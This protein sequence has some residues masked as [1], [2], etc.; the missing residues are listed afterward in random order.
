MKRFIILLV[1]S[2]IVLSSKAQ[3]SVSQKEIGLTT[4]D[5]E[6]FGL[7]YMSGTSTSLWR[8]S[9]F[10]SSGNIQEYIQDTASNTLNKNLSVAFKIGKEFRKMVAKN[11]EFRYGVDVSCSFRKTSEDITSRTSSFTTLNTEYS[12]ISPG[13]NV[14]LGFN[15]VIKSKLV[16]GAELNPGMSYWFERRDRNYVRQSGGSIVNYEET[17]Q[18]SRIGYTISNTP[19]LFTLAYRLN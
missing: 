17:Y 2:T 8:F 3:Q 14:I 19:V 1:F 10:N 7:S 15:Y 9:T 16:I 12:T 5:F 6:G 11:I 18:T 13:I 4:T